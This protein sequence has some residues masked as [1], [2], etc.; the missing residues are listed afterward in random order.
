MR[1]NIHDNTNFDQEGNA[2]AWKNNMCFYL[3][4]IILSCF[5]TNSIAMGALY[6][7]FRHHKQAYITQTCCIFLFSNGFYG[8]YGIKEQYYSNKL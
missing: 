2:V 1:I 7:M 3:G 4:S 6:C 5:Y 8:H